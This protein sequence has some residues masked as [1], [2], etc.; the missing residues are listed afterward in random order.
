MPPETQLTN[1]NS[2]SQTEIVNTKKLFLFHFMVRD[3]MT[4]KLHDL[5]NVKVALNYKI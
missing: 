2:N 3:L 5:K 4:K 1:S